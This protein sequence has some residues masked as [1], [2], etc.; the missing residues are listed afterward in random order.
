[1]ATALSENRLA[2]GE[3]TTLTVTVRHEEA[4][5]VTVEMPAF[6]GFEVIDGPS[7]RPVSLLQGADTIRVVEVRTT[8]RASEPGR[9]VLPPLQLQVAGQQYQSDARLVEVGPRGARSRVPFLLRWRTTTD[10]VV[11]GQAIPVYL[12]A[13]NASEYFFP[14]SVAVPAPSAAILEEVQ[15][16]GSVDQA[17]VDGVALYTVPIAVY[18]VTPTEEGTLVLPSAT[19]ARDDLQA[20]SDSLTV[21]VDGTPAAIAAS[22]AVGSFTYAASVD[23]D[24]LSVTGEVALRLS[25]S[26]TGNLQFLQV[27]D[28]ELDG[29]EVVAES[30]EDRFAAVPGG[31]QGE[32]VRVVRLSPTRSGAL[33]IR[34]SRFRWLDPSSGRVQAASAEE[35]AVVAT[36]AAQP[37]PSFDLNIEPLTVE[38]IRA[39]DRRTWHDT[40]ASIG[41]I[42]P[43]LLVLIAIRLFRPRAAAA[44]ALVCASLILID[45]YSDRLPTEDLV[46]AH[47]LAQAGEIRAALSATERASRSVSD[48]PGINYNLAIYYSR[49]GDLPRAVFAA[50]EA[51]RLAPARS[52]PRELLGHIETRAGITRTIPPPHRLHPDVFVLATAVLVNALFVG[53]ALIRRRRPVVFLGAILLVLLTIASAVLL[54]TTAFT[55]ETQLAVAIEPITLT[56]IPGPASDGWLPVAGGTSLRIVADQG[57]ALLVETSL[58]L[59][60][61]AR[62]QDLIWPESPLLSVVRYRAFGG[63]H[64]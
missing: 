55:H 12:E 8:V 44:I 62:L 32:I 28:P 6:D 17:S 54:L 64:L 27:P 13:Y 19:V 52:A 38:E 63:E 34:P 41:L 47:E 45:A 31:Y 60:G 40:T 56:R 50:R 23:T 36:D 49:L 10:A 35:I 18:I 7:I 58:G 39:L 25:V 9:Y 30:R 21:Q 15:G 46:R 11:V 37:A 53:A 22:G 48:S 3:S 16:L 61:W 20:T 26:G 14:T 59:Q 33:S 4:S 57:D 24:E 51:I 2:V 29:L 5:D 42:A 43:G 1:M